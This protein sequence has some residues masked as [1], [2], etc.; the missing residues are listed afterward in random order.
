ME[1]FSKTPWGLITGILLVIVISYSIGKNSC[2]AQVE[3]KP[4]AEP[5]NKPVPEK[6][7]KQEPKPEI[8]TES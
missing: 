1:N 6:S 7:K 2:R 3:V 8:K 5:I 4:A